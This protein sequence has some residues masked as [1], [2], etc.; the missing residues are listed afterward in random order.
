MSR[1]KLRII[2][3]VSL[4]LAFFS[5]LKAEILTPY[6]AETTDPAPVVIVCPG[7]SYSWLDRETE[8]VGV[9][10]W[11]QSQG[12]SAF[13]LEYPVQGV[14]SF[15]SHYR[16]IFRGHQHP[17]AINALQRVIREVRAKADEY[18][19]DPHRLGV[20]GFSAGGHLVASAAEFFTSDEDRPDFS[21]PVYPV[22]TLR[23]NPWVHKRSRRALLGEYR[24][25]KALWQ[26][27][28]SL[29]L[30]VRPDMP[31]VFLVNCVDDPI[32]HYHNSEM[33][34]SALT[35][36]GVPHEYHQYKTGG[37]GFGADPKKASDECIAWKDAFI[38][39]FDAQFR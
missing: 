14:L 36:A 37:H 18:H 4:F 19:I 13:V 29:E 35:A 17:D 25:R 32:V 15:W 24:K 38:R 5:L 2:T 31:P 9:A 8:G 22:V 6:L 16:Y 21:V 26:D 34:D 1:N 11:L 28:L 3:L 33:L 7:G 12:I 23:N 20:M 30:H 10:Q 27:S 39:W